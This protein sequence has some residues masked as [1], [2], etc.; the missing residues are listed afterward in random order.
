MNRARE[1]G[2]EEKV[3]R[4]KEGKKTK[5]NKLFS[6]YGT[7]CTLELGLCMGASVVPRSSCECG[8]YSSFMV[9]CSV[10]GEDGVGSRR[11]L[12]YE[13]PADTHSLCF[14]FL[15]RRGVDR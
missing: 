6:E 4:G 14:L 8:T 3:G 12:V 11:N 2:I 5:K 9:K 13:F 10:G 1:E 7:L 15:F